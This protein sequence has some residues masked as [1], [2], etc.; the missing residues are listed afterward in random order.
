VSTPDT[1]TRFN[2]TIPAPPSGT[3]WLADSNA[4][5]QLAIDAFGA[6]SVAPSNSAWLS[7]TFFTPSNYSSNLWTTSN[8][9][10]EITGVQ[11]ETGSSATSFEFR[12]YRN[13][14]ELCRRYYDK[15]FPEGTPAASNVTQDAPGIAVYML[16]SNT[17][18]PIPFAKEKRRVPTI[19]FFNP[20][21]GI[22]GAVSSDF[23]LSSNVSA[24]AVNNRAFGVSTTDANLN[25][26]NIYFNWAVEADFV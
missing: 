20:Y 8:N 21:N 4:G 18:N 7:G 25:D 24:F 16:G 10:I 12:S 5:I 19:T 14:I 3:T 23:A 22:P 1:Y 9:Y 17:A 15:S 2:T 13:E 26:R 11:L 6:F